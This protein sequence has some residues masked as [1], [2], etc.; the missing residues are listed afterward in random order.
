MK[1]L[2]NE[3]LC[4]TPNFKKPAKGGPANFARLFFN[5]LKK[6]VKNLEWCGIIINDLDQDNDC[7]SL[8]TLEDD[9]K[10]TIHYFSF[11]FLFTNKILKAKKVLDYRQVLAIPIKKLSLVVKKI[12]PDVVF[13]NGFSLGNWLI[14]EAARKNNIPVVIQHAGIWFKE[15][16]VYQDF[17]SPAGVK[18]MKE[19]ERDS[20][21][22]SD[23]EIFL[24]N[25]SRSYFD[26]K[27]LKGKRAKE[28]KFIIIPLPVDFSFFE[29]HQAEK[30]KF[31]FDN[32]KFNIGLVARWDRI[33]NHEAV[34]KLSVEIK[35][36]KL[37]WIINSVTS[38]PESNINIEVKKSYRD[39][40]KVIDF[41]TK[42]EIKDFCSSNDLIII[43]SKF[44]V[45]PTIL[46]E[47]VACKTPVAISS[48]V[49][50]VD[51]YHKFGAKDWVINFENSQLAVESLIKIKNKKLPV[52][53][54]K[55]LINNHNLETVFQKYLYLL[56]EITKTI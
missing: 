9:K 37:P 28:N 40:V 14:L 49:G 36:R 22:S 5:F 15:L 11:P 16:E 23:R 21:V 53:L 44:D 6:K 27:V 34:A 54:T 38:I 20:S 17:Y 35:K 1:I 47:A 32:K 45:S 2:T 29:K 13:L 33:K 31:K 25:F 43:P 12:S 7:F 42:K 41:L 56:N 46:L 10:R 4:N 30:T 26:Q 39:N 18:I 48:S 50:F 24:N 8:K 51:D 19:M 55:N 52:K 3:Y